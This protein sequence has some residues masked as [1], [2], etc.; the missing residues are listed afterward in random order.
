MEPAARAM[1]LRILVYKAT[2]I[3]EIDAAFTSLVPERPDALF[4]APTSFFFSRR[5]QLVN[6]ASLLPSQSPRPPFRRVTIP[7]SAV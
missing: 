1:G 2:T 5:S 7:K 3:H 4:I 6:L